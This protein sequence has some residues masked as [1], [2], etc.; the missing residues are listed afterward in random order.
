MVYLLFVKFLYCCIITIQFIEFSRY[1]NKL[2]NFIKNPV[3]FSEFFNSEG[4]Y[5][6][7]DP[8]MRLVYSDS[9]RHGS[10]AYLGGTSQKVAKF[11]TRGL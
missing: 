2:T 9:N 8:G 10:Q 7:N 4:S 5:L 1:K 3:D 11:G 6:R